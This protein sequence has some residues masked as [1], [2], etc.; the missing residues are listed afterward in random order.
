LF[1]ELKT[2]FERSAYLNQLHNVKYRHILA[3]LRL[4]S[5]KLNIEID[6]HITIDRQYKKCIR[7]NLNDIEDVFHFILVCPDYIY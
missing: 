6:R 2:V 5:Y 1:R 4:S 3:K 7:C